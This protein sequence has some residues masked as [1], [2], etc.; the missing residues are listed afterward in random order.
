MSRLAAVAKFPW[1]TLVVA[2]LFAAI[3]AWAQDNPSPTSGRM[4]S[5]RTAYGTTLEAYSAGPPDAQ[6]GVLLVHDRWGVN[7]RVRDWA[8]RIAGLGYR[9]LAIDLYD[10]RPVARPELGKE[11]WRSI[12]P[13]WI[14]A[15]VNAGL[16]ELQR[17]QSKIV[18]AGWGKGIGPVGDLARRSS[19]SLSGLIVY[20]DEDTRNQASALPT[21]LT[22]PVLDI[23]VQR[24]LVYPRRDPATA[25]ATEDV[26]QA[27][28][29]FLARFAE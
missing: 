20:F 21:R 29:Q 15:D 10:G 27:T 4:I 8:D 25:K 19:G 2:G 22:V 3:A 23:S 5:L 13:V 14:E 24:S 7:D 11:V 12:D 18:V 1:F 26:W 6:L 16:A 17:G 28:S 9:A